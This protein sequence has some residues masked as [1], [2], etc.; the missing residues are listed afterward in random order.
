MPAPVLSCLPVNTGSETLM[1]TKSCHAADPL[2]RSG[3]PF[4]VTS[5]AILLMSKRKTGAN[6]LQRP[7]FCCAQLSCKIT[8]FSR[9]SLFLIH[10]R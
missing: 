1:I 6:Y 4:M 8:A 3:Q 7:R 5:A 9:S 2:S 10:V